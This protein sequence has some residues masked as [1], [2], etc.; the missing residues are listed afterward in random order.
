MLREVQK[1]IEPNQC[2]VYREGSLPE[3]NEVYDQIFA[4]D[5]LE[6]IKDA[7]SIVSRL[8]KMLK[9][10][11]TLIAQVSPK[12][13]FQPQH[14]T[15]LDLNQHG[16]LQTDIYTYVRDDSDMALN[17]ARNVQTVKDNMIVRPLLKSDAKEVQK[18][19][20]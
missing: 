18:V 2:K 14:I 20:L 16:F 17:Y 3:E 9:R 7:A 6:H 8:R 10:N 12:S 15:E 13:V 19:N 5:V 4:L 1:L 11:G